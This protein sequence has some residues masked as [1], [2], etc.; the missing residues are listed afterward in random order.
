MFVRLG[1]EWELLQRG[2]F[3]FLSNVLEG[4]LFSIDEGSRREI[5]RLICRG[6][7]EDQLADQ[8]HDEGLRR[9]NT[10]QWSA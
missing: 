9:M 10:N 1:H 2:K 8:S 5:A 7:D 4:S 3:C 6:A